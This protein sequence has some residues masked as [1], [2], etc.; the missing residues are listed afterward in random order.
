MQWA[1][2]VAE[3]NP[4]H[5]GHAYQIQQ[6]RRALGGEAGIAAVM[7]GN[8]VQSADCAIA[9]KWTRARLA[10][11][12]GADLVLELPTVWAM[13]SAESFARGA[14]ELLAAAGAVDVLSFGSECGDAGRLEQVAACL[15][16]PA[17]QQALRRLVDGGAPFAACRQAA[18]GE[19]L[20]EEL[21]GLLARPNNNLGVEYIR[22]L[23]A[24]KSGIR[25][26]TVLRRGAPH[27]EV[28]FRHGAQSAPSGPAFMAMPQF[29]SAT[30]I[31]MDL[32]AGDWDQAEPYLLPGSR[33]LLERNMMTGRPGLRRV[34]RAVLARVR[35]MTA[36]DWARLP[37]SG[38]AE[39]L[40]RRL[41]RAGRQCRS[42]EEFFDLAKTRRFP[43]A[44]L[45]RLLLWAYLGLARADRP[46]HPPYLRVLGFNGRGR[47]LLRTMKERA[48][49]P[50]L[51]KPAHART[52]DEA[53]RRLFELEARCTDLYDLCLET[54]PAPG[55][56]WTT[57]PVVLE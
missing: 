10:L 49:L 37:D 14:V 19:V 52:L 56:E 20:G 54:V 21:A 13:S 1:G 34:E 18:V 12:G 11:M 26:M 28:V 45:R 5:T 33:V 2:I 47:E 31:R 36:E 42:M 7:S 40:P 17:C 6:T 38:A 23:R 57:G 29:M 48:A 53:G 44:R 41:E 43:H 46:E 32:M 3:Y 9:D 27:N 39:G 50:V 35:T 30:Q 51:T 8:W 15:D 16:S 22:A 24:L 4:F 25:P 55:R